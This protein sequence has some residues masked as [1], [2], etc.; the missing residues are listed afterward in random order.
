VGVEKVE[1]PHYLDHGGF[2]AEIDTYLDSD[3]YQTAF[4]EAIVPDYRGYHMSLLRS[5]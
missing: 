1:T 5:R 2:G 4:G 3:E